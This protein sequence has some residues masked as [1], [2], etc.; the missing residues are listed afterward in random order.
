[1]YDKT[2]CPGNWTDHYDDVY[3]G[4]NSTA[5]MLHD[6][7]PARITQVLGPDGNPV[8]VDVPRRAIG[9]DLR[10]VRNG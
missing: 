10:G 9:F 5:P 6:V 8:R 1:M 2:P 3:S 7:P 4:G